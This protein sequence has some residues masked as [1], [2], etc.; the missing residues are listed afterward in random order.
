[1]YRDFID[2]DVISV[3]G[4]KLPSGK[5]YYL[6]NNGKVVYASQYYVKNHF[7]REEISAIVDLTTGLIATYERQTEIK[8]EIQIANKCI[9]RKPKTSLSLSEKNRINAITYLNLRANR[10]RDFYDVPNNFLDDVYKKYT[11]G[12]ELTDNQINKY[13]ELRKRIE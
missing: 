10:L 13:L 7:S 8:T 5:A 2:N 6:D 4:R 11:K 1:M 12:K 3:C 9:T